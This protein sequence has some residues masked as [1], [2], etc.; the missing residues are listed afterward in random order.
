MVAPFIVLLRGRDSQIAIFARP[1][2]EAPVAVGLRRLTAADS[3]AQAAHDTAEEVHRAK[4]LFGIIRFAMLKQL[5]KDFI[6][7]TNSGGSIKAASYVRTLDILGPILT[8][9]Y[10]RP[11]VNGSMRHVFSLADIHALHEWICAELKKGAASPV[12]PDFESQN[13]WTKNFCILQS[14]GKRLRNGQQEK[15]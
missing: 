7:S 12:S 1:P 14:F 3:T 13:Y 8:R 5:F 10:P 6:F 2:P 15:Q 9:H 4:V 11:V